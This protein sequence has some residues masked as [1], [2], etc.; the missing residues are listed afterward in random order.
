MWLYDIGYDIYSEDMK[1][2]IFVIRQDVDENF[3]AKKF[4]F[5]ARPKIFR[6]RPIFTVVEEWYTHES[7]G[8]TGDWD[9]Y[10]FATRAEACFFVAKLCMKLNSPQQRRLMA[11][12]EDFV[13]DILKEHKKASKEMDLLQKAKN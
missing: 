3:F 8:T 9:F 6:H 5:P 4:G 10:T 13:T 12:A 1:R 11:V 2:K 7:Q